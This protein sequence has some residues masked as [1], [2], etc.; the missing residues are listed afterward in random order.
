[1]KYVK[2]TFLSF[3][4]LFT[5][6]PIQAGFKDTFIRALPKV[7]IGASGYLSV[8]PLLQ[9]HNNK[10]TLEAYAQKNA[11][12]AATLRANMMFK[13]HGVLRANE[14]IPV[15]KGKEYACVHDTYITIPSEPDSPHAIFDYTTTM[16][17]EKD[18]FD[19]RIVLWRSIINS[20]FMMTS[21]ASICLATKKIVPA[22]CPIIKSI[23]FA[24]SPVWGIW[25]SL[26]VMY[27]LACSDER[28]ADNYA[29]KHSLYPERLK[30]QARAFRHLHDQ[31]WSAIEMLAADPDAGFDMPNRPFL[32]AAI[33]TLPSAMHPKALSLMRYIE[34]IP[35]TH[36][37]DLERAEYF[38]KAAQELRK[39]QQGKKS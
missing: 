11:D 14:Q 23:Y 9:Y 26:P 3:C 17:H 37:F 21:W 7:A 33:K 18:H 2:I 16:L 24:T 5:A 8:S 31:E 19:D 39:K 27:Y 20:G 34:R 6:L 4:A 30:A 32:A 15:V 22:E 1:M 36:P 13:E 10:R 35:D 38:K 25:P 28:K 12:P 29:I